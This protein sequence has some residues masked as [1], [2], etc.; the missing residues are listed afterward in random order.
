MPKKKRGT[1]KKPRSGPRSNKAKGRNHQKYVIEKIHDR[2]G[3]PF[4]LE[5][6]DLVFRSMGAAGVDIILSPKA[7]R[8]LPLSWECKAMRQ[9]PA[10]AAIEQARANAYENTFPIVCWKPHG[11]VRTESVVMMNLLDFL[12]L[13]VRLR[14]EGMDFEDIPEQEGWGG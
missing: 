12:N 3:R 9:R 14:E 10:L 1:R 7:K 2:M 6:G 5:R 4:G 13:V 8:A 11:A